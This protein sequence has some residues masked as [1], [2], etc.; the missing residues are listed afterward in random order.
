MSYFSVQVVPKSGESLP[1]FL[2]RLAK[3]NGYFELD[4]LMTKHQLNHIYRGTGALYDKT[5]QELGISE[6]LKIRDFGSIKSNGFL[7]NCRVCPTCVKASLPILENWQ[8][9]TAYHCDLHH[10]VLVETCQACH[11]NLTWDLPVLDAKCSNQYCS[12][13]LPEIASKLRALSKEAFEDCYTAFTWANMAVDIGNMNRSEQLAFGYE[14]LTCDK[15]FLPLIKEYLTQQAQYSGYPDTMRFW[16]AYSC[17]SGLNQDWALRSALLTAIQKLSTEHFAITSGTLTPLYVPHDFKKHYLEGIPLDETYFTLRK[18]YISTKKVE[19]DT[20]SKEH[21][22]FSNLIS[23]LCRFAIPKDSST[24]SLRHWPSVIAPYRVSAT[25]VILACCQGDI[26]FYFDKNDQ[27]LDSLH[28]SEI[29]MRKFVFSHL[30]K[31]ENGHVDAQAASLICQLS[32]E[33]IYA[34][35]REGLLKTY[36][37]NNF[38]RR[39]FRVRDVLKLARLLDNQLPLPLNSAA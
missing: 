23:A 4:R 34:A 14:V 6:Q 33:Q 36:R 27:L 1:G 31:F 24:V 25:D 35:K 22:S 19:F 32:T 3:R 12:A 17:L 18:S 30:D 11:K 2:L 15:T 29:H 38:T 28:I 37:V 10:T 13:P 5:V 9:T 26:D 16:Q 20:V 21:F 39:S 8:S 7:K